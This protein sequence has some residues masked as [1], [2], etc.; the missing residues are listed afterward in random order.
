M[1]K[2]NGTNKLL[3]GLLVIIIL[4]LISAISLFGYNLY[5]KPKL[6]GNNPPAQKAVSEKFIAVDEITTNLADEGANKY[7][8]IRITLGYTEKKLDKEIP[9]KMTVIK[10]DIL[11]TLM[12]KD[13]E[14]FKGQ[15]YNKVANEL[16]E[17]INSVLDAGEI[18]N[19]YL[20]NFIIQ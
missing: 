6:A 5:I 15:G 18:T 12:N 1:S 19:L 7:I 9:S 16:K 17:K 3:V 2:N 4:I 11:L 10:N 13:S 8:R 14:D 20:N